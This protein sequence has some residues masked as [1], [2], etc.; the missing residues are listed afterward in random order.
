RLSRVGC[1][2]QL[3]EF[4]TEL[5][6]RFGEPPEPVQRML[7]LTEVKIEAAVWQICSIH[8]ENQY[9]VFKFTHRKRIEQLAKLT[10]GKLRVVD[11]QSAYLTLP[12][13]PIAPVEVFAL[14]KSVLRA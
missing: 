10:G 4:R 8:I 1:F 6:D 5:V 9:L 14:A 2:D 12:K 13:S 11:E 7:A 3:A